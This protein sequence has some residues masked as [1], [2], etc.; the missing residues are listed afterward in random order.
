[1]LYEVI[2]IIPAIEQAKE[3]GILAIGPY[4][5]DG[6]FGSGDYTK[7]DAILAMYHDQGV[8][9]SYSIHYTKLYEFQIRVAFADFINPALFKTN[10]PDANPCQG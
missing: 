5:S 6:F 3:E 7:F 9:T 1:M 2:T 8:I 4:P 10:F